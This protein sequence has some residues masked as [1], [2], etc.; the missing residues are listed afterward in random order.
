MSICA[1]CCEPAELQDSHVIPEFL[2]EP[3]YDA[4]HRF[5]VYQVSGEVQRK[6]NQKGL[7]EKMLCSGCEQ[8][9]AKYERYVSLLFEGRTSAA[10]RAINDVV[11]V[12]PIN[13]RSLRLFLL[14][15]LWRSGVS[16]QQFFSRVSLGRHEEELRK[17]LLAEEVAPNWRYGCMLSAPLLNGEPQFDLMLQP[18]EVR[19]DGYR[20]YRYLFGGLHWSFFAA[21]HPHPKG[22][23]VLS[24]DGSTDLRILRTD[25]R[26]MKYAEDTFRKVAAYKRDPDL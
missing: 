13:Y 20:V 6:F 18:T 24:L 3:L 22:L 14:S 15:I 1:L 25:F 11:V 8:Q 5:Q 17:M 12:S 26:D 19:V 21:S 7:R 4:I 9:I 10:A 16:K 2:Y 23:E